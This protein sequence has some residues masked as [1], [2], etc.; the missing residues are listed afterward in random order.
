MVPVVNAAVGRP[1]SIVIERA[2]EVAVLPATVESVTVKLHVPSAS[3]PKV[4]P[5]ETIVHVTSD[6]PALVAVT[7]AVPVNVPETD[8]VG[9]SSF[10]TLSVAEL[11]RSDPEVK[12]GVAGVEILCEL[13]T[14]PVSATES[15]EST[16]PTVCFTLIEYVP[17]GSVENVHE[18]VVPDAV[19]V[20]VTGLPVEGVA[21]T[22]TDAPEVRPDKSR[23][24][25][26]SAVELS[27][28]DEPRSDPA[29]RSGTEGTAIVVVI[30]TS[31]TAEVPPAGCLT[32]R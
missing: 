2:E 24:G 31:E 12:S 26:L 16:P 28:E 32:T 29:A 8:I 5:P 10:V 7:T 25:V 11:P 6:E 22:V 23:V 30:E 1:V 18:P 3:V 14:I 20:Q 15:A 27:V 13:I 17:F 9:V 21:V 4:Q 19:N